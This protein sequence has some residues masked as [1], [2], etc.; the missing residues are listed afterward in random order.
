MPF[1]DNISKIAKQ[2]GDGA[3]TAAKK[4][5]E[6]VEVTKL[7]H[8]ISAEEDKKKVIYRKIGEVIYKKF[9]IGEKIDEDI[10][11][12]C[13]NIEDVDNNIKEIQAKINDIKNV[14]P[15]PCCGCE[16]PKESVACPKCGA[17]LN[18]INT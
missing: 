18:I 7:N 13:S 1:L 6:M 8:S 11:E 12:Y 2:V 14:K 10:I 16:L 5:S 9:L 4:S 15:C 17:K 3:T